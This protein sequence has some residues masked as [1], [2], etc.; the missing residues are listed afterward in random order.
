MN[1]EIQQVLSGERQWCVVEGDSLAILPTL[2]EKAVD[3]VIADPPYEAEAH[4]KGRRVQRERN[5]SASHG[6]TVREEVLP[7][8]PITEQDR[9]ESAKHIAR[10]SRRWSLVFCQVEA[11]MKWRSSVEAG[12]AK[13]KRTAI[14]HKPDGQPQFTGDRPGMGYESIVCCH[15][16]GRSRWNGGGRLGVFSFPKGEGNGKNEH[17]T[18]KPLALMRELVTLF[19]DPGDVI[20]DPFCGSGTTLV[21]ALSTGRRCIGIELNPKYAALS[22]ERAAAAENG[23]TLNAARAGQISLFGAAQ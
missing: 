20:L 22:R 3:H 23:L 4:T 18:T 5:S 12:G 13:Y 11:A 14:W 16:P 1:P 15:A 8:P 2:P 21:A 6:R 19:T 9:E 7:F 17:P 10:I